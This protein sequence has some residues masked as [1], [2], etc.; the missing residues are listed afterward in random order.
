MAEM[1][2]ELKAKSVAAPADALVL[3]ADQTLERADGEIVGKPASLAD[4]RAQLL[5]LRGQEH[6]LHSAAVLVRGGERVWGLAESAALTVRPF[7]EASSTIISR[8]KARSILGSAG[9]YRVEALGRAAVQRDRRQPFCYIGAAAPAAAGGAAP[10]EHGDVMTVILGLTGSIGM[11]KSTVARM[12]ER[13]RRP[14]CS[15]PTPW[16][17]SCRDRKAS[18][19]RRSRRASP[20]PPARRRRPHRPC[21]AG[22]CRARGP[23]ESRGADPSGGGARARAPSLRPMA[24]RRWSCS[25]SPCCSR[26]AAPARST[27]SRSCR[28]RPT[29]S[30]RGCWRGRE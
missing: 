16:S 27:R 15:T 2:A 1:L 10:A 24:T 3:G 14:A 19:S 21:R 17:T 11:G 8:A 23:A 6:Q 4:A 29:S 22:A 28:R 30:A 7:S 20:A 25:T 9:A 18:W 12:F 5:S 13:G 26:K